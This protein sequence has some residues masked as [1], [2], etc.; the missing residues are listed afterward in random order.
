MNKIT[1]LNDPIPLAKNSEFELLLRVLRALRNIFTKNPNNYN[2]SKY[3]GH[4]A[5]TGS[6]V[7][8]LLHKNIKFDL[9][10]MTL[11]Q[12]SDVVIVL[13][14]VKTLRQAIELKKKYAIKKIIAGPNIVVF[15]SDYNSILAS[16]EFDFVVVPRQRVSDCYVEDIPSIIE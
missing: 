8:G 14:G 16:K 6:I 5:V 15:S 11:H 10:P 9:N 12:L 1:I 4:F 13:S 3:R 2:K 7:R